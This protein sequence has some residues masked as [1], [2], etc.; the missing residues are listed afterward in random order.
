MA[1]PNYYQV[2]G[3]QKTATSDEIKATYR[4]LAK[5][6]HPDRFAE[7]PEKEEA[8]ARFQALTEAYNILSDDSM[9]R[10]YDE[11]GLEEKKVSLEN[12]DPAT[13]AK[14]F[15][16]NGVSRFKEE[17]FVQ[18]A[19]YFG[20]AVKIQ[21]EVAKYHAHVGEALGRIPARYKDAVAAYEKA[22]ELEPYNYRWLIS[23]GRIYK[24]ANMPLRARKCFE[25]VLKW[26]DANPTA[27]KELVE[28]SEILGDGKPKGLLGGIASVLKKK[29]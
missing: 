6:W 25:Q 5:Q 28:I 23:L 29:R 27:N 3:L 13:Q 17:D 10:R 19:D 15:F 2:L 16:H 18:A 26:D 9:R 11:G 22:L 24:N 7:G 8:E 4:K 1:Q 21:P 12:L 14:L 20:Q